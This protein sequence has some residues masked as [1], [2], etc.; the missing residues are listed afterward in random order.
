MGA[1][2]PLR[3]AARACRHGDRPRSANPQTTVTV[4]TLA[5]AFLGTTAAHTHKRVPATLAGALSGGIIGMC[6]GIA[7]L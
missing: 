6:A 3:D 7:F 2:R 5:F 1:A 4:S